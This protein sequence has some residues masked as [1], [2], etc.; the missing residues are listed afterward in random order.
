MSPQITLKSEEIKKDPVE[1]LDVS[2]PITIMSEQD[3]YISERMKDQP[4]DLLD[5][6]VTTKEEKFGIH[7]LSLPEFFEHLSYDCTIGTTCKFHG[8]TKK[9]VVYS[10]DK[11]MD[12]WIQTK[13]GKYV[14]RWLNKN[15]RALDQSMNIKAWYLVNK[16]YF[17]EAPKI[18][19]SVNGGVENGDSILGFM[20][21]KKALYLRAQPSKDSQERVRSESDKHE[22]NPN[23][24]KA[25][26]DSENADP[27]FAPAGALIEDRDF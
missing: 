12:R 18:L 17:N 16:S 1:T 8:W 20:P 26:L 19:F 27:D 24:Y 11:E 4:K 3:A 15:K 23:F 6:E 25:K 21:V 7:R 10:L 14:F 2:R 22:G 5:I 13:H 9:K